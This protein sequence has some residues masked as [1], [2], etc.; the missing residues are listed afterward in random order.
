MFDTED[1][2]K[3]GFGFPAVPKE[4]VGKLYVAKYFRASAKAPLEVMVA[5]IKA[6]YRKRIDA[7]TWMSP[8]TKAE[9]E[10]KLTTLTVAV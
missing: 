2:K 4:A 7:L 1:A 8:K 6:A 3:A 10:R 9:A 5:N